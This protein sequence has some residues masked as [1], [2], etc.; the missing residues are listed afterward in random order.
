M[1]AIWEFVHSLFIKLCKM[2][3]IRVIKYK[4]N[5]RLNNKLKI[6]LKGSLVISISVTQYKSNHSN[7]VFQ[8]VHFQ[9]YLF[10]Y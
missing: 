8:D 5:R 1:T 4:L 7:L 6:R 10:F 3:I 2:C 9:C